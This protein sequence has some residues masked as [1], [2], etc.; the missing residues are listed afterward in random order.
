MVAKTVKQVGKSE[1]FPRA[2]MYLA[3]L[4]FLDLLFSL[5][6]GLP[7]AGRGLTMSIRTATVSSDLTEHTLSMQPRMDQRRLRGKRQPPPEA[8]APPKRATDGEDRRLIGGNVP[9]HSPVRDHSR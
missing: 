7:P 3:K 8:A 9:G 4:V 5:S 1:N 2:V 6:D